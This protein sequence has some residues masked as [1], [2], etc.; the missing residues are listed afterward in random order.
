MLLDTHA[1]VWAVSQDKRLG[2][3][4]RV[5]LDQHWSG[6]SVAVSAVSFWEIALLAERG[7]LRLPKAVDEYRTAV[8]E[9]GLIEVGLDGTTAIRAIDLHGFPDDPADRFIVA[10]ALTHGAILVTGDERL[11]AW[12]HGLERQDARL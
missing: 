10:T 5:A 4:T 7:R 1:L 11:L 8:L 3:R 2:R 12:K 9:A 6:G